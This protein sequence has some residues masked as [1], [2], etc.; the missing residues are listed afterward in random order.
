[1][2]ADL[3]FHTN[4]T[5]LTISYFS[6]SIRPSCHVQPGQCDSQP[7]MNGGSCSEGWNRYICDCTATSFTGPICGK[8][9]ATM[10]FNGTQY[11]SIGLP[12][13]FRTQTEDLVLRFRTTRHA[14]LIFTTNNDYYGDKL[15]LTVAKSKLRF[16]MRIGGLDEVRSE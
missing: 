9:A 8:E 6:A 12:E 10:T 7:C 5:A 2:S 4:K 3:P 13:E 14:G 15:E 11:M 1:M 16:R